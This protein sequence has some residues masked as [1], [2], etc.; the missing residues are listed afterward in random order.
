MDKVNWTDKPVLVTGATGLLGG[1]MTKK[2]INSK[3]GVV[4]LMRDWSP[5]SEFCRC[6]LTDFVNVVDGDVTDQKLIERILGEYEVE[7]VFHLAAQT[8]VSIA[9]RNPIS[10]F[11]SNIKG[12]W[13]LLEACRRSPKVKS[14][15]VASSDKCYTEDCRLPYKEDMPLGGS[16]PYDV[17]K[18]CADLI[19]QSYAKTYKLP[20]AITRCGYFYGGGDLNWNR[21]VPGTIR[22]I[23]RGQ[24]PIIRSDGQYIRDYFYIEDAVEAYMALAE[25]LLVNPQLY[26]QAFNFSNGWPYTVEAIVNEIIKQMGSKLKPMIKNEVSNEIL[27]Q[28]I[29]AEK[30]HIILGWENKYSVAEGLQKTIEWY[31]EYF[32]E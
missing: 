1:W 28:T 11:E 2:L 14:I 32:N 10:T 26:G 3:A 27:E 22:S 20:V 5:D 7:V 29:S 30:A 9:N 12:T 13:S 25:Q 16:Y 8:I 4:C 17:S 23:I 31:K 15:V 6:E 18:S 21:I 19:A 24:Q